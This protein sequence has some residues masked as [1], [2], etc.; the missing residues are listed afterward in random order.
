[1]TREELLAQAEAL[2]WALEFG[3]TRED[4]FYSARELRA[5]AEAMNNGAATNAGRAHVNLGTSGSAT[6][7]AAR[8][9]PR[10]RWRMYVQTMK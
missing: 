8:P 2:E 4:I 5:K 9:L 7:D 3:V 1:M 6:E 10:S